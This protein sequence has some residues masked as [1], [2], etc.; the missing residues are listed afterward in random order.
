MKF[1][2]LTHRVLA[3]YLN[4]S[5]QTKKICYSRACIQLECPSFVYCLGFLSAF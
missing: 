3:T 1:S 4:N 5:S 2:V